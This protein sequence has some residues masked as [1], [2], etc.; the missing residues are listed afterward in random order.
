MT[1]TTA[2]GEGGAFQLRE[3]TTQT[4]APLLLVENKRYGS[5][6]PCL[7]KDA[8]VFQITDGRMEILVARLDF[9][10]AARRESGCYSNSSL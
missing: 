3:P 1:V 2:S 4:P 7:R 10:L 9:S 8:N 6:A 5:A